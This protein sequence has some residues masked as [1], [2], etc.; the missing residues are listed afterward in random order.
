M[1]SK[2]R[3]L[4]IG[5]VSLLVLA[6]VGYFAF[7][8]FLF[9]PHGGRVKFDLAGL[10]PRDVDAY[11]S[12]EDLAAAFADFPTLSVWEDLEG[13][14]A[15]RE[16]LAS[17]GWGELDAEHRIT[18]QIAE[19]REQIASLPLGIDPLGAIGGED[20]ALAADFTGPS[21]EESEWAVYARAGFFGKL[22]ASALRY[23]GLI[24]LESQGLSATKDGAV[25]TLS[26]GQLKAPIHVTRVKDVVVAGTS[27]RLVDEAPR[28][29]IAGAQESLLLAAPYDDGVLGVTGR[30]EDRR[31]IEV[32]LDLRKLREAWGLDKP[33][34]DPA[35]DRFGNAFA[36]R[37]LPVAAV[38]QLFGVLD[39]DQGLKANLSG[40]FSSEL[41]T[42]NQE[43]IYRAKGFSK[44]ELEEVANLAPSD[45]TMFAYMRAPIGTLLRLVEDSLEPAA[46][47]NLNDTLKRVNGLSGGT[48][49][50]INVLDGALVDRVAFFVRP[51]DWED[52]SIDFEVD[53]DTGEK[54]YIGPPRDD[55]PVF[56]WAL[57]AWASDQGAIDDLQAAFGQAG[58]RIGIQG[59]N[60]GDKG[61][62]VTTIEGGLR[63]QEFWSQ[64]IP[65][66]GHIA[67]LSYGDKVIL[68]NRYQFVEDVTKNAVGRSR[69]GDRL[70]E[71]ASFQR[72]LTDGLESANIALWLAPDTGSDLIRTQSRDVA[73]A[74][75]AD[76]VSAKFATERPKAE[77]RVLERQFPGQSRNQVDRD[78]LRDAVDAELFNWRDQQVAERLPAELESVDRLVTYL[79]AIQGSLTQ[80][81][82]DPREFRLYTK[83]VTPY[84]R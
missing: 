68:S 49:S 3:L 17:P 67:M 80:I 19:V 4:R 60:P 31:D 63:L 12:R 52:R 50:L 41:M 47:A 54:R 53:P 6:F 56:G 16:Y 57:V 61:Y 24:G 42:P 84:A 64:L 75:L 1:S 5:C 78:R 40:T 58:P 62:F 76:V 23:P 48:A 65:G 69:P 36:A 2:K 79:N 21:A 37:V 32:K 7:S 59:K 15:V 44:D 83:T 8:T 18:E 51:N 14:S 20:L 43:T 22:G 27:R 30:N 11:V 72:A 71:L 66:T 34:P 38:R 29:E 81:R 9:P 28:L 45:S 73:S 26:G 25:V 74:R 39:F 35:S 13:N 55:K 82:L 70:G 33:W 10:I 46:Q 77:R